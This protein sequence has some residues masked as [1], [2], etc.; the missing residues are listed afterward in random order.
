VA[1]IDEVHKTSVY[2]KLNDAVILLRQ[3]GR[4]SGRENKALAQGIAELAQKIPPLRSSVDGYL[5]VLQPLVQTLII[6]K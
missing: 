6:D 2:V 5:A 3:N 4:L 1:R